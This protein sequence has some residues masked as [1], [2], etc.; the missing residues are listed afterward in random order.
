MLC[1][2]RVDLLYGYKFNLHYFNN[3]NIFDGRNA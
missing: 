1:S 3:I 2:I